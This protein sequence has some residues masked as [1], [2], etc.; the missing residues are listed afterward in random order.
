MRAMGPKP[1]EREPGPGAE[2]GAEPTAGSAAPTATPTAAPQP[3]VQ[4]QRTAYAE[5]QRPIPPNHNPLGGEWG[6]WW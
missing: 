4:Q 2:P 1:N 3:T 5:S 6:Y